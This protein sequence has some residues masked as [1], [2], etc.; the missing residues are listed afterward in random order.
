MTSTGPILAAPVVKLEPSSSI[1][2]EAPAKKIRL[3]KVQLKSTVVGSSFRIAKASLED[4]PSDNND[5]EL[6]GNSLQVKRIENGLDKK[7]IKK[8]EVGY[9]TS[10]NIDVNK[11]VPFSTSLEDLQVQ[12]T[13][14][15]K[16]V[17]GRVAD[18]IIKSK[19]VYSLIKLVREE[20]LLLSSSFIAYAFGGDIF[21][22]RTNSSLLDSAK[23]L[24]KNCF[25]THDK[26][27]CLEGNKKT[28][29]KSQVEKMIMLEVEDIRENEV[30]VFKE[31]KRKK[32][33]ALDFP[34]VAINLVASVFGKFYKMELLVSQKKLSWCGKLHLLLF[35]SNSIVK[36]LPLVQEL[37]GDGTP[38]IMVFQPLSGPYVSLP[39]LR[40]LNVL[41]IDI[42]MLWKVSGAYF[43]QYGFLDQHLKQLVLG[44]E[45]LTIA[46]KTLLL[47]L[48]RNLIIG[49]FS[50]VPLDP[51]MV[52]LEAWRIN[53]ESM[54]SIVFTV[55]CAFRC[56]TVFEEDISIHFLE[57]RSCASDKL[58]PRSDMFTWKH[59]KCK[60]I[61]RG[62][63]IS[64]WISF[65]NF[66]LCEYEILDGLDETNVIGNGAPGKAILSTGELKQKG[67]DSHATAI[68]KLLVTEVQIITSEV[69]T[70]EATYALLGENDATKPIHRSSAILVVDKASQKQ[71][72]DMGRRPNVVVSKVADKEFV[73]IGLIDA[74]PVLFFSLQC[75]FVKHEFWKHKLKDALWS[76]SEV[77]RHALFLSCF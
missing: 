10:R 30:V 53:I 59:Q 44:G 72:R 6:Q 52:F 60:N 51:G 71:G 24:K 67:S 11:P 61:R 35:V 36:I 42:E 69:A 21:K 29:L 68:Y 62:I 32:Y 65:H 1:I 58:S 27:M 4:L 74:V 46:I 20:G 77:G 15:I 48:G 28:N 49:D 63:I 12:N 18:S 47:V 39:T 7:G 2:T 76:S 3:T 50:K 55:L 19:M 33:T 43:R 17:T 57:R 34:K 64:N 8:E 5:L 26:H 31:I 16:G 45:L 56:L 13:H 70:N 22:R 54:H 41:L 14:T 23:Q 40:K 75:D 25:S 73:D 37:P 9:S 66:G 38:K